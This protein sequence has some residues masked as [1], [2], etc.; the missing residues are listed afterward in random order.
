MVYSDVVNKGWIL[1]KKGKYTLRDVHEVQTD[2]L[3][4]GY[5]ESTLSEKEAAFI[6]KASAI[7]WDT[8]YSQAVAQV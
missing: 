7:H 5:G 2:S 6:V 3:F 1:A 8:D 4:G